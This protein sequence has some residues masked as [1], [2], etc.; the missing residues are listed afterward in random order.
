MGN[1]ASCRRM[2]TVPTN[3]AASWDVGAFCFVLG[4]CCVLSYG[5]VY[6]RD[7]DLK[8]P[9]YQKTAAYGHFGR[10]N[11]PWEVPKKLKYWICWAS[12]PPDLLV[13]ITE[14][15]S[16]SFVGKS[17]QPLNWSFPSLLLKLSTLFTTMNNISPLGRGR[18]LHCAFSS[19][20]CGLD[21]RAS[22]SLGTI[23]KKTNKK[24]HR[25]RKKRL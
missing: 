16:G 15:S 24:I 17:P 14:K 5:L 19:A 12:F 23:Q 1:L 7:L 11:F 21:V 6:S 10:N 2:M 18:K 22:L 20:W 3:S 4:E 9:I 13:Y 25:E 8:K